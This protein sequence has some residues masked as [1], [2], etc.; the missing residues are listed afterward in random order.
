MIFNNR[1][2][3]Y[4]LNQSTEFLFFIHH[5]FIFFAALI[6]IDEALVKSVENEEGLLMEVITSAF[7]FAPIITL[8]LRCNHDFN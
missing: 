8:I 6:V 2:R 5:Y 7:V 1:K 4:L 3:E